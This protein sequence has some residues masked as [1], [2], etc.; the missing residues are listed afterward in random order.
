[1][2]TLLAPSR[3]RFF[4]LGAGAVVA[5]RAA[6]PPRILL[7]SSWQSVNIGDVGHTPGA[8]SLIEKYFPEAEVTLWPGNLGH[9]SREL[10]T[11]GY[12][13]LKIAEG[14]LGKDGKPNSPALAK[15]WE[16]TD[17]YL[18]GS[19]SGFPAAN[20]AVAFHKVTGKPIG[21]FGVS[22]DPISG[23]SPGREPEGGTLEQIR[24]KA[25]KL[26]ATHLSADL[27]W[28]MDRSAFFFC[29]DTIS[30]DY[31]KA[32]GVKTPILEFGPDAQLGMH[33]R[34]DAKGYGWL[35]AHGLEEGKFICVLPR[36]R[37]TPY[38]KIRNTARVADDHVKDAINDR[39]TA[40]DH[41]KLRDM[42]VAYVKKTGNKVM[43][44]AEMTYQVELGKEVLVDP[45]P[46]EV[47][48]NVV[49]RDSFWMPD[50]AAS[51]YAKAQAV[52]S[53]E[54][55]SPLIS[56]RSG[57]PAFYVRQPT[58]TCKGQMYRDMGA[59]DWFFEIDETSGD[60]LW[61]RLSAIHRDP[62]KARA[63][64]KSI[65]SFVEGRQKRMVDA[66]RQACRAT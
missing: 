2:E 50:E 41:A 23:T 52:V 57:T 33:L 13:R 64:V 25:A 39:T 56:F 35:S 62:A 58:D 53:I 32:Q 24:A 9:G 6:K 11:K 36:L 27:R 29:R 20:H 31:L 37:Y 10:L 40:K 14:S 49:W 34:D 4:A 19:G 15:A 17:L 66:V 5:A 48:K 61:S 18:S 26:P 28:V 12:P 44:C 42:I 3:R 54:C 55:H 63:K 21:V 45:L 43:V 60:Q 47:K 46:A 38:Y 1:M 22:T 8:L 7:R 30:R 65:M 59:N 51:I 16:E